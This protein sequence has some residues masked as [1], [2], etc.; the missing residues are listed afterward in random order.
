MPGRERER[1]HPKSN[2]ARG[3]VQQLE[4]ALFGVTIVAYLT[5]SV[6]STVVLAYRKWGLGRFSSAVALVGFV[7][8][9]ASI[10]VRWIDAGRPP[11]TNV[12]ETLV[13]L[14]WCTVL[15]FL[16]VDRRFHIGATAVILL[17]AAFFMVA[18]GALLYEAP[19][20]LQEELRS[21][22]LAVHAGI[23]ILGYAGFTLAFATGLLYVV[24]ED[25]MKKKYGQVRMLTHG[26]VALLGTGMGTYVGY[27]VADPTLFEDATGHRV[28]A[29]VASDLIIIA[30]GA[31][32]GLLVSL[33]F[34]WFVARGVSR[35]AFA[36]R[37]PSLSLLDSLGFGGVIFGVVLL[38][39]GI[40]SGAIWARVAWGEWWSWDPKETWALLA[41][42]FYAGYLFMREFAN[43]RGRHAAMLAIAGMF[44]ILFAFLGINFFVPGRHDFN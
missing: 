4:Q 21:G 5:A 3:R 43:W 39:L 44:L 12:Y 17:P 1:R 42:V 24:Q 26:L 11:L 14:S 32:A 36:G 37:L 15:L 9:T 31:G 18:V 38:A 22:W 13:F 16:V 6:L 29:Y 23:T 33:L 25:L 41:W 2:R 8:Q 20:P 35:P 7:A 30:I 28:Y 40:M 27:L 19:L 10:V 34:G